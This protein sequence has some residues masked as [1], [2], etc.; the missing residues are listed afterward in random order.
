MSFVSVL[1]RIG[2]VLANVASIEAIG[3]PIIKQL[4]PQTS[5]TVDK[6]D[7]I[8]K[9]IYGVEGMFA[10]AYPGQQTGPEKLLAAS[11]LIAPI[12]ASVDSIAGTHTEDTAAKQAA[13]AKIVGGFADYVNALTGGNA[14]ALASGAITVIPTTLTVLPPAA[15]PA[16]P[17]P[18]AAP[19]KP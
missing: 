11:T 19:P 17:A 5:A 15:P 12:L 6:L 8:F 9:N 1:K 10:A 3:V 18:S 14:Q 16:L 13:I 4:A 2:T 7:L